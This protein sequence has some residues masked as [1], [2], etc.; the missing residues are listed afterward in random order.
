MRHQLIAVGTMALS[1]AASSQQRQN[2]SKPGAE[3]LQLTGQ[4]LIAPKEPARPCPRKT[5]YLLKI[6][7]LRAVNGLPIPSDS[8]RIVL[9]FPV[10]T[11]AE[12]RWTA[13]VS[14]GLYAPSMVINPTALA[15]RPV[16]AKAP[17]ASAGNIYISDEVCRT[18]EE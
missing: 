17:K 10:T 6:E 16:N 12:G 2:A 1:I 11:D 5:L 9:A 7:M 14:P 8:F 13:N 4:I 15:S 18:R 3:D